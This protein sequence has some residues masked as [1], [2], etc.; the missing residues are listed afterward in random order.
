[1][2]L[3]INHARIVHL[4]WELKL[5]KILIHGGEAVKVANHNECML[6]SWLYTEGLKSYKHFPETMLLEGA[7]AQFH[8]LAQKVVN[9]HARGREQKAAEHFKQVQ[10]L[11]REIIFLLTKI[12]FRVIQRK[13]TVDKIKAPFRFVGNLFSKKKSDCEC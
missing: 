3:D 6:G 5:E 2:L 11:S 12:E 8:D 4:E 1:M 9:E 10:E 7:H 13:K